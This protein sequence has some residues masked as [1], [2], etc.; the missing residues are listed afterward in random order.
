MLEKDFQKQVMQ[1]ANFRGWRIHHTR[2]VQVGKNHFTPLIGD[3][4]FPDLVMVHPNYGCIF[5]SS[6]RTV[7]VSVNIKLTGLTN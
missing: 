7:A 6:K 2:S 3:R 1:L 4:G 5:V